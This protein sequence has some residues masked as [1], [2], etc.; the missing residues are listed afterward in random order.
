MSLFNKP[1]ISPVR[2]KLPPSKPFK[3]HN[4]PRLLDRAR[5][6]EAKD[7][8]A[9]VTLRYAAND[10][11]TPRSVADKLNRRADRLEKAL[12][13]PAMLGDNP[14]GRGRKGKGRNKII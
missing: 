9:I 4:A 1:Y 6:Q 10:G 8:A 13:K 3:L 2:V 11:E 5:V 7:R 12:P 14:R